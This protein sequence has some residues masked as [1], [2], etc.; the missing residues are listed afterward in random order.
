ME[1]EICQIVFGTGGYSIQQI[2]NAKDNGQIK[3]FIINQ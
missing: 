2:Q 3:D 1:V